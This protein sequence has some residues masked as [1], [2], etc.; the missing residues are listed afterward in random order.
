MYVD[1]CKQHALH[2]PS[3]TG[4]WCLRAYRLLPPVE[5]WQQNKGSGA[6]G[7]TA[8]GRGSEHAQLGRRDRGAGK[9]Y[10]AK[11]SL[12]H[13]GKTREAQDVTAE[14]ACF[15][16]MVACKFVTNTESPGQYSMFFSSALD[17]ADVASN[18][19]LRELGY[20]GGNASVAS[21]MEF[22]L[23]LSC[24]AATQSECLFA[25]KLGFSDL[26]V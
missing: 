1:V 26:V 25:G 3:T 21:L 12:E 2:T 7:K 24:T 15:H 11:T 13:Q 8:G 6:E 16:I 19:R 20:P 14:V 23:L 5:T 9:Q 17:A 4:D 10:H 22:S 18:V